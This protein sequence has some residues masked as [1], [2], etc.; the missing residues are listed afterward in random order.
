M[1][2]SDDSSAVLTS[3][4]CPMLVHARARDREAPPRQRG[5]RL[6]IL[7]LLAG[8]ALCGLAVKIATAYPAGDALRGIASNDAEHCWHGAR[9]DVQWVA[10]VVEGLVDARVYE[11]AGAETLHEDRYRTANPGP[12]AT[13][14]GDEWARC[15][16]RR[17]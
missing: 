5:Y 4:A 1:D 7:L 12:P 13:T 2:P 10:L 15:S 3:Y 9:S 14:R 16:A 8:A 6:V 11:Y 17:E